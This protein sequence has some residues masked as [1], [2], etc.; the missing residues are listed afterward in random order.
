MHR[1]NC[2]SYAPN[3]ILCAEKCKTLAKPCSGC[4]L[5][6]P[7]NLL[8]F[9]ADAVKVLAPRPIPDPEASLPD[10]LQWLAI[11]H[12]QALEM[13]NHLVDSLLNRFRA[14]APPGLIP[15]YIPR[16]RPRP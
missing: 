8:R 7:K 2:V 6:T 1:Q 13:L 11:E 4:S 9:P 5:I 10:K 16:H 12:P 3:T 14:S 15:G